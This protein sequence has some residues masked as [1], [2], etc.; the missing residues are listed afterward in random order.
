MVKIMAKIKSDIFN[1][2][3]T[4]YGDGLVSRIE[5]KDSF[6][7]QAVVESIRKGTGQMANSYHPLPNTMLQAYATI[8]QYADADD[9]DV[10][11]DIGE[12]PYDD[13]VVY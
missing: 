6:A 7:K 12:I 8:L 13:G 1:T 2:D 5:C 3:I 11:G 9:I 4:I 10:D